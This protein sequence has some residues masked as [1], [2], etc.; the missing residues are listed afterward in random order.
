[1]E[2]IEEKRV[3]TK[4]TQCILRGGSN[5]GT[6]KKKALGLLTGSRVLNFKDKKGK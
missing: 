1:M 5:F 3:Q 4:K 2:I 6:S